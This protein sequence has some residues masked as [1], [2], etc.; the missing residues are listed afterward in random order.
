MTVGLLVA[1]PSLSGSLLRIP[2]AA[3]VEAAGGRKPFL[4]L[5]GVSI[6]GMAG[7]TALMFALYPQGFGPALLPVLFLLGLCAAA[8]SRLFRWARPGVLLVPA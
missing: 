1:I 7:L 6:V 2:F 4:M 8:A 3:A 5:L